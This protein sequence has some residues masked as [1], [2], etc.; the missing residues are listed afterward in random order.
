MRK[1]PDIG[2]TT[3]IRHNIKHR[4]E[5]EI[6]ALILGAANKCTMRKT[7][8]MCEAFLSYSQIEE[9][10]ALLSEK[11]LLEYQRGAMTHRTTEKGKHFLEK[12]YMHAS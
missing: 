7:R 2:A 6:T 11:G 5:D 9:Y 3:I 1:T 8:L 10:L 12:V 4:T